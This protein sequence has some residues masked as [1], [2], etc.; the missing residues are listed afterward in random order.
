M[1]LNVRGTALGQHRDQRLL[2][3]CGMSQHTGIRSYGSG[4]RSGN[5]QSTSAA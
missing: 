4:T 3:D 1:H 2:I 5:R